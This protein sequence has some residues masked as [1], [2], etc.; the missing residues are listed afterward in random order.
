MLVNENVTEGVEQKCSHHERHEGEQNL[1]GAGCRPYSLPA[2][3]GHETHSDGRQK[4]QGNMREQSLDGE[5]GIQTVL[6]GLE[7]IFEK[8][9]PTQDE[10]DVE[11]K[12]SAHVGVHGTR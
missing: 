7:K 2:Q 12:A 5:S 10:A 3:Q 6:H 4:R 9:C 8:H 1:I 11:V